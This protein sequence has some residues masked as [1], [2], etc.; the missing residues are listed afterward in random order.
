[1]ALYHNDTH[2]DSLTAPTHLFWQSTHLHYTKNGVVSEKISLGQSG[3]TDA[4]P[5]L[6]IVCHTIHIR[7][8][9]TCPTTPL[10]RYFTPP[11]LAG[12]VTAHDLTLAFRRSAS[13]LHSR[14]NINPLE[15]SARSTRPGG[16]T[17][18]LCANI[19][20]DMIRL[21]GRWRSDEML[22][23]LHVQTI[24]AMQHLAR[25]MVTHGSFPFPTPSPPP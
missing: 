18:L 9:T 6:A 10:Y 4:C 14:L 20:P 1:M 21:L 19:D 2:L 17:A 5:V 25:L 8:H 7:A 11:A 23:Y 22:R 13:A 3:A 24:P 16:A 15:L 12:S